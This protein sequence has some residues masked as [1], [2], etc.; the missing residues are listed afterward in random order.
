MTKWGTS[1]LLKGILGK[2]FGFCVSHAESRLYSQWITCTYVGNWFIASTGALLGIFRSVFSYGLNYIIFMLSD[3]MFKRPL[4]IVD[5][6][7]IC[8]QKS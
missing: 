1:L 8:R 6:I 4:H 3:V 7:H 5:K 2:Q